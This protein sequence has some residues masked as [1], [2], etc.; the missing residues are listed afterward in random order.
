MSDE[1]PPPYSAVAATPLV[2][3]VP[4]LEPPTFDTT[5][6]NRIPVAESPE[7]GLPFN[8]SDLFAAKI[9][10]LVSEGQTLDSR[11]KDVRDVASACAK[12]EY[13]EP[14]LILS[15][16]F[17][18]LVWESRNIAGIALV[19]AK[20]FNEV[21]L[22]FL[23]EEDAVVQDRLK[24]LTNASKFL[25]RE[26]GSAANQKS[27]FDAL[28]KELEDF[29]QT[30]H[31]ELG[32][33]SKRRRQSYSS[34]KESRAARLSRK[35]RPLY[36]VPRSEPLCG[37]STVTASLGAVSKSCMDYT[38]K[39]E[40]MAEEAFLPLCGVSLPLEAQ[41]E[42][43]TP[44]AAPP[45]PPERKR[46]CPSAERSESAALPRL[47]DALVRDLRAFVSRLDVFDTVFVELARAQDIFILY[48]KDGQSVANQGYRLE[49]N[50]LRRHLPS[51][52]NA[53]DTYSKARLS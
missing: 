28:I 27:S 3:W 7:I 5:R 43:A 32:A 34:G 8:H 52:C 10:A 23:S 17:E 31:S 15:Q 49:I 25:Q 1:S 39:F 14:A 48:L 21:I 47:V 30:I 36:T 40:R 13:Q 4:V 42:G 9:R 37:L 41:T 53:L 11:F 24:E 29:H 50:R 46:F 35:S 44:A 2:E 51:V 26:R 22:D 20:D 33:I 6:K 18:A 16:R 12:F 19:A 45:N 38:L